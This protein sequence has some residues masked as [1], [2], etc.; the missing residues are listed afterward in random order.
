MAWVWE[1]ENLRKVFLCRGTPENGFR[2]GGEVV[3]QSVA[4]VE[5]LS[6]IIGS[7]YRFTSVSLLIRVTI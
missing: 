3:R 5:A 7:V 4:L 1:S 6:Q 2:E